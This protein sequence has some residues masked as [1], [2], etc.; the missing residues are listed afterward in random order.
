VSTE[1]N[2]AIVRRFWEEVTRGNFDVVDELVSPDYVQYL[3]YLTNAFGS[4]G[5]KAML[6]Q[7]HAG[8]TDW[9]SSIVD[10]LADGDRVIIRAVNQATHSGN[11]RL[12][13]GGSVPPT[14]KRLRQIQIVIYQVVDGKIVADWGVTDNLDALHELGLLRTSGQ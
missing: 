4:R 5:L 2:K 9:E 6:E 13:W 14:G 12:P 11:L 7:T 8:L 3:P 10:L 1:E